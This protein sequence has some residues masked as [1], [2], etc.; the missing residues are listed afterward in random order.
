MARPT[1]LAI[2]IYEPCSCYNAQTLTLTERTGGNLDTVSDTVFRV[3]WGD[4]TDLSELLEVVHLDVVARKVKH[5]VL[6]G[7][8]F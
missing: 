2:P 8:P 7:T 6:E 5:D 1:A 3:T 4:G